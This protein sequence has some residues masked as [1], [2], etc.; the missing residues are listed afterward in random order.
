MLLVRRGGASARRRTGPRFEGLPPVGASACRAPETFAL[1]R[2]NR[3]IPSAPAIGALARGFV[4]F[5]AR[6]AEEALPC[7]RK[8]FFDGCL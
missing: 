5:G 2:G 1:A 4:L 7:V 8:F 6:C 3:A